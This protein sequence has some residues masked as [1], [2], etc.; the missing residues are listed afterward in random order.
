MYIIGRTCRS[1]GS[2]LI[3]EHKMII[4]Y[5]DNHIELTIPSD[6]AERQGHRSQV[7]SIPN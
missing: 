6:I 2:I 3:N 1:K 4:L 7:L 5:I